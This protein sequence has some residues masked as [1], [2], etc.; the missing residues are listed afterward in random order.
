LRIDTT[1]ATEGDIVPR[2]HYLT[3]LATPGF[4]VALMGPRGGPL[5]LRRIR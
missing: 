5:R 1:T 2:G 3:L 4:D